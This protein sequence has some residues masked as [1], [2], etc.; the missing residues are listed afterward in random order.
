MERGKPAEDW[1]AVGLFAE[2]HFEPVDGVRVLAA[3][4]VKHIVFVVDLKDL[5]H[6]IVGALQR[7]TG[8]VVVNVHITS[9]SQRV[10]LVGR[11]ASVML[12]CWW[13]DGAHV[14]LELAEELRGCSHIPWLM[15]EEL[16]GDAEG[17][18][19]HEI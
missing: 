15:R 4:H 9:E 14:V 12:I 10:G 3:F 19:V 5:E 8:S 6:R 18:A 1:G 11:V 16:P 13:Q 7:T 17:S 2:C